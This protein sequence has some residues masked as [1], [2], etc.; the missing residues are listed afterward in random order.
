M[1]MNFPRPISNREFLVVNTV[2]KEGNRTFFGN[3]SCPYKFKQ[4]E[5]TVMA[6]VKASGFI[7]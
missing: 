5:D 3:R 1:V 4:H 7:I 6:L 2:E